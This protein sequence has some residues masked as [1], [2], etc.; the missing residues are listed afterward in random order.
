MQLVQLANRAVAARPAARARSVVAL[1][2]R[3]ALRVRTQAQ[4]GGSGGLDADELSAKA[5]EL[6]KDLQVRVRASGAQL[7]LPRQDKPPGRRRRLPRSQ[8]L[9][10]TAVARAPC[11]G[12]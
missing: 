6:A 2:S 5:S 4:S 10:P 7:Q 11:R 8:W 12:R 9:A 1:P 3:P